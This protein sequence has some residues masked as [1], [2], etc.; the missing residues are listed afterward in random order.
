MDN[1]HIFR[2]PR[3]PLSLTVD[4]R[5]TSAKCG[6]STERHAMIVNGLNKEFAEH[7]QT[8]QSNVGLH[9]ADFSGSVGGQHTVFG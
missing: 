4:L 8:I 6:A 2:A 5:D 9:I 3:I 1:A 7:L